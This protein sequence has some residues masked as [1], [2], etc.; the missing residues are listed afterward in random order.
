MTDEKE[1]ITLLISKGDKIAGAAVGGAIGFLIGGPLGAAAGGPIGI[2]TEK[3][4]SDFAD[5]ILSEREKIRVGATATYAILKIKSYIDEGQDPRT[6]GFFDVN[7]GERSDAEEI[8]EGVLLKAKNDHEEKKAKILGNIFANIAFSRDVS[9]GEANHFLQIAGNL[10]YRQMVVISLI[11]RKKQIEGVELSR[12]GLKRKRWEKISSDTISILQG[13]YELYNLGLI[14]QKTNV[15]IND[16]T[17]NV[18]LS[19]LEQI[20]PGR[21][22]LT[23]FGDRC[24]KTMG[25]MDISEE[26]LKEIANYID[27]ESFWLDP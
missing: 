13:I 24:Y 9:V 4:I 5:R 8:F 27:D 22:T 6:D 11:A 23:P 16:L 3:L 10:S 21:L 7:G 15:T 17:G 19:G 2:A 25:L 20:I 26:E 18:V 12:E 1:K 14:R